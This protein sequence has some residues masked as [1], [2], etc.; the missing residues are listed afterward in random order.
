MCSKVTDVLK[1]ELYICNFQDKLSYS[2]II[3]HTYFCLNS[4]WAQNIFNNFSVPYFFEIHNVLLKRQCSFIRAIILVCWTVSNLRY[5]GVFGIP[6]S[7]HKIL[8]NRF[9]LLFINFSPLI[10]EKIFCRCVKNTIIMVF[11][12][13]P[14]LCFSIP[15][16]FLFYECLYCDNATNAACPMWFPVWSPN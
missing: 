13:Y 4:R 12:C 3:S 5:L 10:T 15:L 16:W 11:P 7:L 6:V 2:Q 1:L 14:V 9:S 8:L